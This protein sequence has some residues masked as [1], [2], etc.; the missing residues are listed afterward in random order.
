MEMIVSANRASRELAF[1][2]LKMR[3]PNDSSA[4]LQRRFA[5]LWL[6]EELAGK[7][8]GPLPADESARG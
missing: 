6:G 8:Y 3:F 7:A 1:S 2:G 4:R 5:T